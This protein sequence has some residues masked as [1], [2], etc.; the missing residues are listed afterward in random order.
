MTALLSARDATRTAPRR[1]DIQ[2]GTQPA[3]TQQFATLAS[4]IRLPYVEHGDRAGV[5]VVLLHGITDSWHSF[6]PI[7]PFLPPSIRAF[8]L[9][10][11]GHGDADRPASGYRTRDFS[12]DVVA[13]IDALG[14][15]SVIVVGHS[16]GSTNAVRFALDNPERVRG[17]VLVGA[18]AAYGSN[19]GVV[20]F[21]NSCVSK[22]SDPIPQELAREFQ[23]STLARPIAPEFL[24]LVVQES[25]KAPAHVW[26]DAFAGLLEDDFTPDL[27][28]IDA[29]TLCVWGD[30]D[31]FPQRAD[32]DRF[33]A[34]IRNSRLLVYEG[35][36][37]ALHWEEPARF[38]A[39]LVAFVSELKN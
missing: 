37:H 12:A 34:A 23:E 17:L 22:L 11:R 1:P 26:R 24:N 4:G 21:W 19:E 9:T 7:L 6:E 14:L 28:K 29:P 27:A 18:F 30:R 39:D 31:T 32:Q 36:G 3:P 35:A 13:F 20:E 16:M 33:L 25:L 2:R 38:A 8:A 10:Q 15:D 5:P